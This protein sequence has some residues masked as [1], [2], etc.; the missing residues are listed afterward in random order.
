LP[1]IPALPDSS[2]GPAASDSALLSIWVPF[3]AKVTINGLQTKSTGSR[4]QYVSHGL[5]PGYVYHYE[6]RA[7]IERDGRTVE[8]TR[9]VTLSAGAKMAVA[10]DFNAAAAEGLVAR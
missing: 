8:E 3:D 10:F 2:G 7:E 5:K 9:T 6:I 1:G 4:R